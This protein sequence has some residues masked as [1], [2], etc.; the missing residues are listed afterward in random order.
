MLSDPTYARRWEKKLQ[1]YAEMGLQPNGS[2]NAKGERFVTS[3]NRHDGA[4]DS[5]QIRQQV[6]DVFEL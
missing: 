5:A 6:R 4:I 1:W 2:E 3:Q